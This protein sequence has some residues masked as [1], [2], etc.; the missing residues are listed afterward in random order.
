MK[1][2]EKELSEAIAYDPRPKCDSCGKIIVG[3]AHKNPT[4]DENF[5]LQEGLW[6]CDDCNLPPM[7]LGED[8]LL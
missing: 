1:E 3:E 2:F 7:P 6:E 5:E 8:N 4:Y